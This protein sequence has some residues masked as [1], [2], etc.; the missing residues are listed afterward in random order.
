[1]EP[2]FKTIRL[3]VSR[4]DFFAISVFRVPERA[5]LVFYL[6]VVAL[7]CSFTMLYRLGAGTLTNDE[8]MYGG[9]VDRICDHGDWLYLMEADGGHYW[10]NP[11]LAFWMAALTRDFFEDCPVRWSL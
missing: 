1:M 8:A 5:R 2:L 10:A 9:I 6:L 3:G 11:P 4:E 7:L